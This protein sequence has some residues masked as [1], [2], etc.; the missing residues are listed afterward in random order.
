MTF[1]DVVVDELMSKTRTGL[2]NFIADCTRNGLRVIGI[3]SQII[4]SFGGNAFV[5]VNTRPP[6][7]GYVIN[8]KRIL[9]RL[10]LLVVDILFVFVDLL[11]L[12]PVFISIQT[13]FEK[14]LIFAKH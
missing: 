11:I 4:V 7:V 8:P 5:S 13:L 3:I 1:L 12:N 14:Q 2:T 6:I 10:L 9:N